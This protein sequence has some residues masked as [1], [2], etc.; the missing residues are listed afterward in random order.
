MNHWTQTH[1]WVGYVGFGCIASLLLTYL[2]IA[3]K[4]LQHGEDE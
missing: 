4:K 2:G 3:T 1:V